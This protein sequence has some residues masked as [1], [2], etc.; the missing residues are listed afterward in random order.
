MMSAF[1]RDLTTAQWPRSASELASHGITRAYTRSRHWR[2]TS[3]GYSVPA[4]VPHGSAGQRILNVAPLI[5]RG[6]ALAGWAAA[7]VHGADLLDGQDPE[8]MRPLPVT[9]PVRTALDGARWAG[10]PVEAVVFLDEITRALD[11]PV[12]DLIAAAAASHR[13]GMPLVRRVLPLVEPASANPWESRLRM[14]YMGQAG[15]P[16]PL[17]NMPIF[18]L[19][20]ICSVSRTSSIRRPGWSASSTARNTV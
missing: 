9:S 15:L 11:L 7:Y 16:R 1:E 12:D 17:V 2:R 20:S 4:N 10:D 18:D 14:F 5:P 19:E 13:A 3:R 6:G 8:T